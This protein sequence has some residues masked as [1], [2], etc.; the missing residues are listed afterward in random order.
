MSPAFSVGNWRSSVS[1]STR[2]ARVLDL[3]GFV[4]CKTDWRVY[5]SDALGA[6]RVTATLCQCFDSDSGEW[7]LDDVRYGVIDQ[8]LEACQW[9]FWTGCRCR[10]FGLTLVSVL[11][12][13]PRVCITQCRWQVTRHG[14][15][16]SARHRIRSPSSYGVSRWL[17]GRL[18]TRR[19]PSTDRACCGTM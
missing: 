1:R 14:D 17:L 2:L 7:I 3:I 10:A 18:T 5:L 15:L 13:F 12:C 19:R 8:W 9:Y 6:R 16:A 4:H 11:L